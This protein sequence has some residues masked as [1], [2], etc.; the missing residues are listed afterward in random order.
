MVKRK[1]RFLTIIVWIA[2]TRIMTHKIKLLLKLEKN[3]KTKTKQKA[4]RGEFFWQ[5]VEPPKRVFLFHVHDPHDQRQRYDR[6]IVKYYVVRMPK[7]AQ[8]GDALVMYN[9]GIKILFCL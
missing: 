8:S 4:K 9:Q 2:L 3:Q 5:S 7:T 6:H 1:I